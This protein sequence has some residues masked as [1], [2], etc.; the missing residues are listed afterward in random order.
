MRY[1][2]LVFTFLLTLAA[3]FGCGDKGSDN[4]TP[5]L[6][7]AG[8]LYVLNQADATIYVYDTKTMTKIKTVDSHIAKPHYISFTPDGQ[9]YYIM[10]VDLSGKIAKF[11]ATTD[12]FISDFDLTSAAQAVFPNQRSVIPAGMC[13]TTDGQYGYMCDYTAGTERGH[14]YK[15]NLATMAVEKKIQSGAQTHEILSTTDGKVIVAC[16]LRSDDITLIYTDEDSV[17]FVPID[18]DQQ[19]DPAN[20]RY[21]P[22]CVAVDHHLQKA[23]ISCLYAHQVRI[24]DIYSRQIIDSI[25][26]PVTP[27]ISTSGPAMI[28]HSH[29]GNFLFLTT[30]WGNTVVIVDLIQRQVAAEIPIG[31]GHPFGVA[32]SDDDKR[33]YVAASGQPPKHGYM[34]EIDVTTLKVIDSIEV[35]LDSWGIGWRAD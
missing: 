8:K 9:F 30:K 25:D 4:P 13:I 28:H 11:D 1:S 31:A 10:T 17:T 19:S 23:Y 2:L 26:I 24:L 22:Y 18:P 3:I 32:M 14:V 20:P 5:V 16:N 35:G 34:Y 6:G 12:E 7:P 15:V 33:I 29:N 21:G 27:G